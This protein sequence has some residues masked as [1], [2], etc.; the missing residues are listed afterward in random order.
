MVHYGPRQSSV[1]D[2][3][4][5]FC[6]AGGGAIALDAAGI[7]VRCSVNHWDLAIESHARNFPGVEHDCTDI[8][9]VDP[10]RYPSTAVAIFTPEC[11]FHSLARGTPIRGRRQLLLWDD[12]PPDDPAA[13]RSRATMD[14]VVRFS[15]YHRYKLVFVENVVEVARW[16][17]FDDWLKDMANLGYDY[18]LVCYNSQFAP[19]YPHAAP[20]SR[21][22]LYVVFWQRSIGRAP[23]LEIRPAAYCPQCEREVAAVQS[24]KGKRPWT[25]GRSVGRYNRQYCYRCPACTAEVRP[26]YQAVAQAIDWT[27]PLPLIGERAEPLSEKTLRRIRIGLERYGMVPMIT[28]AGFG[29]GPANL[30]AWPLSSAAPTQTT[31]ETIGVAIPAPFLVELHGGASTARA[32]TEPAHTVC[33]G[34][35]HHGLVVPSGAP[36]AFLAAYY[37]GSDVLAGMGE[38]CPTVSTRDRHGLVVPADGADVRIEDCGYRMLHPDRE[39]KKIMGFPSDY[40]VLGSRRNQTKQLGHSLTPAVVTDLVQRGVAILQ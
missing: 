4:D 8:T 35:N 14:E 27:L 10:Q 30:R 25:P 15:A 34:G 17:R 9:A 28:D 12:V 20:Q 23:D 5:H 11:T 38:A 19:A 29:Y 21:D 26:R 39:I 16:W 18:A 31:A 7:Q 13:V 22:R 24:A 1:L 3:Q 40:V 32:M 33:A 37:S 2:A 6:G 36:G